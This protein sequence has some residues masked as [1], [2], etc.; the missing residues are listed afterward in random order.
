MPLM[1]IGRAMVEIQMSDSP[2]F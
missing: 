2:K 1:R